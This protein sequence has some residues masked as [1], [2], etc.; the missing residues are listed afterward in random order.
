MLYLDVYETID[1]EL[2]YSN[3][4]AR[5]GRNIRDH[6]FVVYAI[7]NNVINGSS[8]S[9]DI[10]SIDITKC[11]DEM[12]FAE[13]HNDLYDVKVQDKNFAL[14]AKLDEEAE[15]VVKTPAGPTNEFKLNELIMQGSV[16]SPIKSTIHIDTLGRDCI[17]YNQGLFKYKNVVSIPPLALIDDCLGF[18]T[19]STDAVQ[20]NSILNNKIASKKLR[21]SSSQCHHIHIARKS[22]K[23]YNN[24]KVG[25][26]I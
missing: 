23:C 26:K 21:L 12:W 24:L 15:V 17:N 16:F 4:G 10:Q 7:I 5:K 2:S 13:T 6:L 20:M 18:S 14:I 9:I 25:A 8:P 11:F 22:W 1:Q 3:I 19:C